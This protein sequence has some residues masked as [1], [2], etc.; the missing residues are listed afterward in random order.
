MSSAAEDDVVA[1]AIVH[2]ARQAEAAGLEYFSI[3]TPDGW[4]APKGFPLR[5]LLCNPATGGS[6]WSVKTKRFLK[7]VGGRLA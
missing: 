3:W 5:E 7:F 6:T 4:V 1:P 2:W